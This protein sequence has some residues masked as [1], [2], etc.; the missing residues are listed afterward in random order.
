MRFWDSSA[1]VPLLVS[2]KQ[3]GAMLALL[4]KDSTMLVWAFTELECLSALYRRQRAGNFSKPAL[5][6]AKER[7]KKL[8]L[9]WHM[10]HD[11]TLVEKQ[12]KRLIALH[13]LR[14]PDSLQLAAAL[15]ACM[16]DPDG[17]EFVCLDKNLAAA[18]ELESFKVIE[19]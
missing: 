11:L 6:E 13:P 12:A 4:E 1:I 15:T 8:S 16:G 19:G 9:A 10:V 3:S 2:E 17:F 14:S 18:A 5:Q 7:L